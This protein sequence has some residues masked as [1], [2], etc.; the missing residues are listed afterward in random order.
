MRKPV[1]MLL[2]LCACVS[3]VSAQTTAGEKSS[4][5]TRSTGN[6]KATVPGGRGKAPIIGQVYIGERA[7]DFVLDG[8]QGGQEQLSKQRGQWVLLAFGERYRDLAGL[9]TLDVHAREVGARVI[10]VAHEKQ[11][12]LT[13]ATARNHVNMLMLADATGEVSAIYGLFDWGANTI[14]PGFFVIDRDGM[15]R[16]AIVGKLFPS[17]QMLELLRFATGTEH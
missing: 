7:P 5:S 16:L 1:L 17:D 10:T 15:V 6:V 4:T 14:E 13:S 12:T 2:A 9:D 11:Q 8:S 3:I